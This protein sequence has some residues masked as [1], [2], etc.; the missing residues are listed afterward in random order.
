M[1]KLL[2]IA[3]LTC[4]KEPLEFKELPLGQDAELISQDGTREKLSANF[5]PATLLFFGFTRC[6]D[7]CPTLLHRLDS[8]LRTR[9]K[10]L[11]QTRL[12]FISVD[13]KRERPENLKTFLQPFPYARG[14]TGSRDQI[15][16]VERAFGAHSETKLSDVSHSLYLYLLNPKGKVIFLLRH[17]DPIERI[18]QALEQASAL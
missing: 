12:I 13:S 16:A 5:R 7:F 2:F 9:P 14:Y 6:P 15:A 4:C 18:I 11:G 3:V 1:K 17:D 10:L 8:A